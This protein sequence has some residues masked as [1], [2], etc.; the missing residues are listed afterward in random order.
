[1]AAAFHQC[2]KEERRGARR[3]GAQARD[4]FCRLP[5][6]N[7]SVRN[8]GRRQN[9]RI[10]FCTNGLV[11]RI[12]S[13]DGMVRW[14]VFRVTPF[15]ALG[16]GERQ[17]IVALAVENIDEGNFRYDTA[18]QPRSQVECRPNQEPARRSAL[19]HNAACSGVSFLNKAVRTGSEIGEAVRFR[20]PPARLMPASPVFPT[21]AHM[22][23]G[24][25][26]AAIDKGQDCRIK[27]WFAAMP[28][29][30]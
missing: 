16:L 29:A 23:D 24:I 11:R 8:A 9:G 18:K 7:P 27:G 26:P 12:S 19:G 15:G 10:G 3:T 1:M 5:V 30:P 6:G 17:R 28:Y 22:R 20:T 21:A 2:L 14:D 13:D 25:D 4:P